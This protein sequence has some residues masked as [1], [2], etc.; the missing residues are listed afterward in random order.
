MTNQVK[1]FLDEVSQ[2]KAIMEKLN[3]AKTSAEVIALAAEK[4][5]TLTEDDLKPE[6]TSGKLDDEELEAVS[7]GTGCGCA[8]YGLGKTDR[9]TKACQCVYLGEGMK[10]KCACVSIGVGVHAED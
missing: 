8:G 7:G 2:D 6:T 1:V 10:K 3:S 5:Y 4:G 9:G